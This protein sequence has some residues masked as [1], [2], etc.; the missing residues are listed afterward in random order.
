MTKIQLFTL[1]LSRSLRTWMLKT[2]VITGCILHI[3]EDKRI[4]KK[5]QQE[6]DDH[7]D[8]LVNYVKRQDTF[9]HWCFLESIRLEPIPTFSLAGRC[10]EDKVLEGYH[11]P[12]NRLGVH[13]DEK[14]VRGIM[15]ALF[16][17]YDVDLEGQTKDGYGQFK[18]DKTSFFALYVANIGVK[19]TNL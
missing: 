4:Q 7:K 6:V 15:T 5:L 11:I 14:V 18:T 16:G 12:A 19:P 1:S 10:T 9:M 2:S 8:N 13:L 3:A 17:Q